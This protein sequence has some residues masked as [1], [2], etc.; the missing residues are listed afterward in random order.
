[1]WLSYIHHFVC[2]KNQCEAIFQRLLF[3]ASSSSSSFIP[4]FIYIVCSFN[5]KFTFTFV[6]VKQ[7]F[8]PPPL[9]SSRQVVVLSFRPV[10]HLA[11][12]RRKYCHVPRSTAQVTITQ[13]HTCAMYCHIFSFFHLCLVFFFILSPYFAV[14]LLAF[15]PVHTC[16][17]VSESKLSININGREMDAD[18]FSSLH[19]IITNVAMWMIPCLTLTFDIFA[20]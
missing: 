6:L 16:E 17:C 1:M 12:A 18:A 5:T 20:I 8:P 9:S 10:Y 11:A 2:E 7:F 4:L 15:F 3:F 19:W 14:I 13:K